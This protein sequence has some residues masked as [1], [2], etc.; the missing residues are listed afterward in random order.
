MNIYPY[1]TDGLSAY[2]YLELIDYIQIAAAIVATFCII[3][4]V[5]CRKVN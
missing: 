1:I 2:N 3:G 5:L 4:I